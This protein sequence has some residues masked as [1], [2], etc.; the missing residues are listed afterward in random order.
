MYKKQIV[1]L[2]VVTSLL[3]FSGCVNTGLGNL[4]STLMGGL[5]DNN[6]TASSNSTSE[7]GDNTAMQSASGGALLVGIGTYFKTGSMKKAL[8][9]AAAGAA[10]G[11]LIGTHL[12][13]MQKNYKGQEEQLISNIIDIDKET[14]ELETKNNDL[15]SELTSI[16]AEITKLQNN[17][18]IK[19]TNKIALKSQLKS[20]LASKK[21]NIETLINNNKKIAQKIASSK[22]QMNTYEYKA[23]DKKELIKSVDIL[24]NKTQKSESS[25][26]NKLASINKLINTLA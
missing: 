8:I 12:A 4:G 10:A 14:S 24:A 1:S 5:T 20:D 7:G 16:E 3:M 11:Y 21:K 19:N 9:G 2:S 13:S 18:T 17:K 26:N 6:T 25:L 22:S 23:E 15:S